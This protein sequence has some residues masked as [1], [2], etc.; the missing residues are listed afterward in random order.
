MEQHL[1]G[2]RSQGVSIVIVP[3][4]MEKDKSQFF[5]LSKQSRLERGSREV[6]WYSQKVPF[7]YFEETSVTKQN[8]EIEENVH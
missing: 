1:T 7:T 2:L 4:P 8:K 3:V 5:W 6:H